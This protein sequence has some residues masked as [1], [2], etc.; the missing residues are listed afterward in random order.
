MI[1]EPTTKELREFCMSRRRQGDEPGLCMETAKANSI[2]NCPLD[3]Q[4]GD[5]Y[6]KEL[7]VD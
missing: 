3:T 4:E 2:Q 7:E 5:C 6:M 1:D